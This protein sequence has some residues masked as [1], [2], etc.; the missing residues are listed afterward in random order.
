[1]RCVLGVLVFDMVARSMITLTPYDKAWREDL[2]L[3]RMPLRM[4]TTAQ[5]ERIVAGEDDKYATLG[6]RYWATLRSVLW[7]WSPIPRGKV[8]PHLNSARDYGKYAV[9]WIGTRLGFMGAL[10]GLDEDWPMFSPNVRRA[11]I[12][13]RAKLVYDDGTRE[14]LW[15][16]GEPY[17]PTSFHRWF[18][19]RP[20]QIDLR[21]AKDYDARLGV[22]RNIAERYATST[23]GAKL[24]SI[25]MFEVKYSLPGP[26]QNARK[27]LAAQAQ[28]PTKE[29]PFWRYDV[30]TDKGHTFDEKKDKEKKKKEAAAAAAAT[31][32]EAEPTSSTPEPTTEAEQVVAAEPAAGGAPNAEEQPEGEESP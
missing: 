30:A 9:V 29:K 32:N 1:M 19:K 15:L 16:L 6:E 27:M 21:L 25:E 26:H 28:K 11:H 14:Q 18:V 12:T 10:L 17:D 2:E 8:V 7:F 20:L 31:A 24:V 5:R 23:E 3:A 4:P 13:P 22:S